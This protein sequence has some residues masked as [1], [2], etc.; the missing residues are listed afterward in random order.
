MISIDL[1]PVGGHNG[2]PSDVY[3]LWPAASSTV[4]RNLMKSTPMHAVVGLVDPDSPSL[5]L[6]TAVHAAVLEPHLYDGIVRV[7]PDVDRRTKEGKATYADFQASMMPG[8]VAISR[9]QSSV[10][11]V[12]RLRVSESEAAQ[13]LLRQAPCREFS[14]HAWIDGVPCKCRC[15]AYGDGICVDVKTTSQL[16]S[17]EAFGDS[18]WRYGYAAQACF[19]RMVLEESG[20]KCTRFCWIACETN[21]PNGVACYEVDGS[22]LD[23]LEPAV[24]KAI[25]VYGKCLESQEWPGYPD[26]VRRLELP[27]WVTRQLEGT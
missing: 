23:H 5:R 1:P 17:P 15:D 24:R 27:A 2:V 14:V 18:V 26:E 16:A 20:R 19:Y 25:A 3:H 7:E 11:D 22:V 13:S 10:V 12:I 9:D 4:I 21:S 6:G 8:Q